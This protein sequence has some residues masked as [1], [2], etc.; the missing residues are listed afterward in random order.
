[1]NNGSVNRFPS[2]SSNSESEREYL[3]A[4]TDNSSEKTDVDKLPD[5]IVLTTSAVPPPSP[6]FFS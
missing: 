1:M 4:I 2:P 6:S 5:N 3:T